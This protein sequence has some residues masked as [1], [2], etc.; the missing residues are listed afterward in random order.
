MKKAIILSLFVII[1][2]SLKAQ[3]F[4]KF[5]LEVG[6]NLSRNINTKGIVGFASSGLRTPRVE[7]SEKDSHTI[8]MSLSAGYRYAEN[9]F[10]RIRFAK[11]TIGSR[12]TGDY[13]SYDGGCVF[14]LGY[15]LMNE[16]NTVRKTSLGLMY[17]YQ[18]VLKNNRFLAGLGLERQWNNYQD[19]KVRVFYM[20]DS[21]FALHTSLGYLYSLFD[22]LEIHPKLFMTTTFTDLVKRDFDHI[23]REYIPLQI[24]F[25]VGARFNFG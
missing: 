9:H 24:G 12:L 10:I 4:N 1:S 7:P 25:E 8:N 5:N 22:F 13:Y 21:N 6:I 3:P 20:P 16:L 18:L 19:S 14:G 23:E 17:E 2:S 11:N 15:T